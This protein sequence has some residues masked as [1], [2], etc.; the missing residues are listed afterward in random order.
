MWNFLVVNEKPKPVDVIIVLGGDM[1][2]VNAG[3]DL[4]EQGYANK[5]LLTGTSAERMNSLAQSLGVPEANIIL[6]EK[7]RTTYENAK[8]SF[9]IMED[10]GFKSAI[11]VTSPYHTRRA[12]IIFH[13][14]FD[15]I[16]VT[17]CSV[18]YDSSISHNWWKSGRTAYQVI[19]EYLKLGWYYLCERWLVQI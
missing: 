12:S 16:D 7:A 10:R 17:M 13:H 11:V 9:Q 5:I 14:F 15:K 8:Y 19:S 6:E 1:S 3:V 4:Y 2:R 18:P